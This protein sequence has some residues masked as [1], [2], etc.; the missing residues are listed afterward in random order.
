MTAMFL[1]INIPLM[2]LALGLW[3]GIP[4]WMIFRYPDRHPRET[5]TIPQYL[6]H[7]PHRGRVL[8]AALRAEMAP[9]GE[10]EREREPER[11]ERELVG[12]SAR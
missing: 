5:R 9:V 12:A 8:P 11:R 10:R 4:F 6:A 3:A 7:S 1:W 2:A